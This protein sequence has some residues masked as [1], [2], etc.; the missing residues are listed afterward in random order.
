M[1]ADLESNARMMHSMYVTG[2]RERGVQF[3]REFEQDA[4]SWRKLASMVARAE[5]DAPTFMDAQFDSITEVRSLTPRVLSEQK[6]FANTKKRYYRKVP[7]KR[8]SAYE[9]QLRMFLGQ[10]TTFS[11]R[12]VTKCYRNRNNLLRDFNMPFPAWF[13]VLLADSSEEGY[14]EVLECY[15]ELAK[16]L[17]ETDSGFRTFLASVEGKYNAARFW[18]CI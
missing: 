13:R 3:A 8:K 1:P 18:Q 16:E 7:K 14:E 6:N 10:F 2:M 9:D 15:G 12:M 17:Y 4:R 5:M 11:R